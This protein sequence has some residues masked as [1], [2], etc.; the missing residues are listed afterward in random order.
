VGTGQCVFGRDAAW[1]EQG[2]AGCDDERT[3][4]AGERGADRLDCALLVRAIFREFRVVV[5]EGEVDQPSDRATPLLR[6]SK[7]CKEPR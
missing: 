1:R 2:D 6:L 4:G 7:S 3:V 5:V